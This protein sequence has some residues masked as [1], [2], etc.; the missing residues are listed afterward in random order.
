VDSLEK[1]GLSLARLV[2]VCEGI[3]TI[4][5]MEAETEAGNE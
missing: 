5:D 1:T 2:G 3:S 4:L